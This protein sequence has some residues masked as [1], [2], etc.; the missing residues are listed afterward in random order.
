MS[1]ATVFVKQ[2]LCSS[3]YADDCVVYVY[4]LTLFRV[5]SGPTEPP[6]PTSPITQSPHP[7]IHKGTSN[8]LR[9]PL[10]PQISTCVL[11]SAKMLHLSKSLKIGFKIWSIFKNW[12][13]LISVF[14][15]SPS[16]QLTYFRRTNKSSLR[17][18]FFAPTVNNTWLYVATGSDSAIVRKQNGVAVYCIV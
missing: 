18:P 8:S 2:R 16:W 13:K 17:W 15:S 7:P 9:P 5:L 4:C 6:H 10:P 1:V 14:Y 12:V 3:P 11:C